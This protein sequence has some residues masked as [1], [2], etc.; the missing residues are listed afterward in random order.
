MNMKM[1]PVMLVMLATIIA[2]IAFLVQGSNMHSQVTIEEAKF[3]QLQSEYFIVSKAE[4]DASLTGSALNQKL[5]EIQN[6][7]SELLRLKLVGVGRI[8]SGIFFLLFAILI[9]LMMMP[10]RLAMIIKGSAQ[11]KE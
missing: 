6:F 3:H 9:A 7:P 4:R 5:V 11:Q 2:G 10:K 8:L 1:M